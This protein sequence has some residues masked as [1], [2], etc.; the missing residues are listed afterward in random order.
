MQ[1]DDT[2]QS[3]ELRVW[4][5]CWDDSDGAA[6]IMLMTGRKRGE[7]VSRR[8]YF[9]H[10]VRTARISP[11]AANGPACAVNDG[12]SREWPKVYCL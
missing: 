4:R 6:S 5:K 12:S 7:S 2:R 11:A 10:K 1:T 3:Q 9:Q 8:R